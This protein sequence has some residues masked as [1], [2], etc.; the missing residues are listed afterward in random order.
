MS[1]RNPANSA[2][3]Q[4]K[5]PDLGDPARWKR[6]ADGKIIVTPDNF[7]RAESD[8]Y[9]A[10]Q[11]KEGAFG[12]F[13]HQRQM[14]DVNH[15]TVIRLN[16]D[17]LY[18]VGLFDLDAGPVTFTLPDPGQRFL[19]ALVI[20]EDHFNPHVFYGAGA[21][22]LERKDIGTR[23][24]M[25]A[26]RTLANPNDPED[27][28]SVHALQDAIKVSQPGGPGRF[29][30]PPWDPES[31]GKVRSALLA[32][33]STLTDMRYAAGPDASSVDPIH[34]LA[35]AAAG[36][37]LNPDK[38][39][40]YLGVNP[41][42]NDGKAVYR[43]KVGQVPVD[44]FWSV[45]VYNAQGYFVPNAQNAYSINSITGKKDKDGSITIQ[46]GGCTPGVPNC[47]PVSPGWNYTVRLYRPRQEI[48]DDSW[49]FPSPEPVR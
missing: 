42:G 22:M 26:I 29:E 14:A 18:S 5:V 39:A 37:G 17:T 9:F 10:A 33:A 32:L 44:A 35:A 46:F 11:V 6:T 7:I 47:L 21:H 27:M 48:L 49:T 36:W 19:S 30:I 40:I 43:L 15:Q 2:G 24:A 41:P 12:K 38:D 23:Y 34:R 45:S 25:V 1:S 16:R 3:P 13:H 28:K 4:S 8:T 31:Q 20:S